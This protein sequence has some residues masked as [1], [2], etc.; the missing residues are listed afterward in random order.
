MATVEPITETVVPKLRVA[1]YVEL[2]KPRIATM[3]LVTVAVG[4]LL[5]APTAEF[6]ADLLVHTLIGAGMV[7]AGGS[8]LNHW[9][10]R[11]ADARMH[12]TANRPLPAG[13]VTPAE[14]VAFGVALG[15]GGVAYLA[16]M[17]PSPAAAIAA[18]L[19]GVLYVAVYTPLK[20]M[21]TWNTV[22]GAVPGALP[23]VIGWCAARGDVTPQVWS[24]FA[25]LFV[26]QLPHFYSIAWLYRHDY[27]R[28]GMKM[29]PVLDHSDGRLTGW[30][31]A[32]TCG[33]LLFV[34]AAPTAVGA[35]GWVYLVGAIPFAVWF[36]ARCVRFAMVRNDRTARTVLRG[37]LVY[38]L[39]V[40]ALLVADGVLPRYLGN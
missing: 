27:A 3:A 9:L 11:R 34:T 6:R 38:L 8:A 13:R 24:L 32:L 37:S 18:A 26:W 29:L 12:R 30:A 14:V 20:R 35:A 36:L 21:T 16:L 23:P 4:F 25:I 15:V 2:T 40:M 33:V 28:G 31:T 7:A 1:D 19:T 17:L 39:G 10:E 5:G 22:I